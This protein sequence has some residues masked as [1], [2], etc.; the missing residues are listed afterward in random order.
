M[1]Q[2]YRDIA[3]AIRTLPGARGWLRAG[4]ELLWSGPVLLLAAYLG[5]L[6]KLG[7]TASLA[8]LPGM[9]ATLFVAPALGEELLFRAALIPRE[10]PSWRWVA[11]SVVLFVLWHPLQA[12][13]VG[14][15]WASAFLDPW[16]LVA[17]AIL[18]TAL[19]RIYAATRSI[20]PCVIA[21]WATVLVWKAFLGGPF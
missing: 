5:G 4:V 13:T 17:V 16:F 18:G 20:W 1:K 15:P 6:I 12:V 8:S 21:H 14:P 9:S 2:R 10:N 3:L 19:A 7:E 11:L